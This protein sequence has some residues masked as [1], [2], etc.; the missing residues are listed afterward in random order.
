MPGESSDQARDVE[1]EPDAPS[2]PQLVQL[3]HKPELGE[4][5]TDA[6]VYTTRV[7]AGQRK[8]SDLQPYIG[9]LL[10]V[11]GL[12]IEDGGSENE[13]I[14]ALLHDAAED[15]GGLSR[16]ADIR[17]R[18][19]E[20]VA[21]IV[22]ECTDTFMPEKPAWRERKERY[23]AHLGDC[24]SAALRVSS[25]DKLDNARSLLRD[26]SVQGERLWHR[27]PASSEDACWYYRALSRRLAELQPGPLADQL[28]QAASELVRAL[29]RSGTPMS[30]GVSPRSDAAREAGASP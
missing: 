1:P 26:Y 6:L 3:E 5:F 2:L 11:T 14:A 16:L 29:G 28:D 10:R 15:Q 9:H 7:H 30:A 18:Y 19:G 8:K 21:G 13:A 22:N 12:V 4:R 23:V 17:V 27:A 24:S 25:A 20:A